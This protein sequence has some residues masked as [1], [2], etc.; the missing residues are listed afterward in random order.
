MI[1]WAAPN[2][3]TISAFTVHNSHVHSNIA[4]LAST[5]KHI[6]LFDT[7]RQ[8]AIHTAA[9]GH[10]RHIHTIKYYKNAY[11]SG[12]SQALNVFLT[13]ACDN[14]IKLWDIRVGTAAGL[15]ACREF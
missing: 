6:T 9:D 5:N 12:D 14:T 13:A 2:T 3:H 4:I 7:E 8:V 10:Q 11:T 1:G 15:T